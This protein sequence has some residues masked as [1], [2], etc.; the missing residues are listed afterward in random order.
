MPGSGISPRL[1]VNNH[2]VLHSLTAPADTTGP[3]PRFHALRLWLTPHRP[4]ELP[5]DFWAT[6]TFSTVAAAEWRHAM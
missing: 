1:L 6:R 3:G 5:P 2:A 4:R